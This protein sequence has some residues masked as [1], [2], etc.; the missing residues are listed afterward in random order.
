MLYAY[1]YSPHAIER[2]KEYVDF[3]MQ[4]VWVTARGEYS[5]RKLMRC[6]GLHS[7]VVA[8][9]RNA[10]LKPLRFKDYLGAP[11]K[12]IYDEF[13]KLR[14]ADRLKIKKWYQA[15]S[16]IQR[17]CEKPSSTFVTYINRLS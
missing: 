3:L 17:L 5:H 10:R 15:N 8:M 4:D 16:N 6:R 1:Q 2:M 9:S 13:L 14:M 7:I 11:I 12:E